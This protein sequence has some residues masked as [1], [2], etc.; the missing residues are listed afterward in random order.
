MPS[1][2]ID[3]FLSD[4]KDR[5]KRNKDKDVQTDIPYSEMNKII[6]LCHSYFQ[7]FIESYSG[8]PMMIKRRNRIFQAVEL[9]GR[10]RKDLPSVD[11]YFGQRPVGMFQGTIAEFEALEYVNVIQTKVMKMSDPKVDVGTLDDDLTSE[12]EEI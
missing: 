4:A 2:D 8:Q 7:A 11:E 12:E 9:L 6:M 5:R 1:D 10:F 3:N